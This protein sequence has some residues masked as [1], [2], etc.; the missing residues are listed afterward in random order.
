MTPGALSQVAGRVIWVTGASRGLGRALCQGLGAAGARIALTARPSAD[1]DQV[2]AALRD[3]GADVLVV[4]AS[5]SD[6]GEVA[7]AAAEIEERWGVLDGLVNAAGVSPVFSS[8]EQVT[9]EDWR[10]IID[11]NLTGSFLCARAAFSLMRERGGSI[12]NVTSVHG[13]VAA[14]RLSAYCASKGGVEMLTRALALDWTGFGVRVNALAPGYFETELTRAL[15]ESEKWRDVLQRRTPMGRFG[16]PDE[17][18]GAT[19]FLMSS[20]SSYVTGTTLTVDGGW[21]AA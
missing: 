15:R 8:A 9:D 14:P 13:R 3:Q 20:A 17:L 7:R 4:P 11:T 2:A 10:L 5:V 16:Q 18:L 21:T 12:V 19:A 1:L 6:P